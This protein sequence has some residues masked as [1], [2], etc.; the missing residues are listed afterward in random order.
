MSSA[1]ENVT[2]A[3]RSPHA[4]GA[5]TSSDFHES[6]PPANT[7]INSIPPRA[8]PPPSPPS[9]LPA[10]ATTS[11]IPEPAGKNI[12]HLEQKLATCEKAGAKAFWTYSLL[13]IQ[14]A[15]RGMD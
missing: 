2:F 5:M 9:P 10:S 8:P 7:M 15:A 6:R 11:A 3:D 1:D 12:R 13:D 4:V 14:L